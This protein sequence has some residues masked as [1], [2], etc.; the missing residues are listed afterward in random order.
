MDLSLVCFV[1][2]LAFLS[3]K[4]LFT[5]R[6]CKYNFVAVISTA[7]TTKKTSLLRRAKTAAKAQKTTAKSPFGLL[8]QGLLR[9]FYPPALQCRNSSIA[10]VTKGA[11]IDLSF[12]VVLVY[13][14]G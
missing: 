3:K 14:N 5:S 8:W 7:F 6:P 9:Q 12:S 11:A 10:A 1:M 13:C 2:V 4:I